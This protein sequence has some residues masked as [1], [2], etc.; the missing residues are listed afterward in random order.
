MYQLNAIPHSR[1]YA[2]PLHIRSR[3]SCH[4]VIGAH[5]S[6][7]FILVRWYAGLLPRTDPRFGTPKSW[8]ILCNRMLVGDLSPSRLR[9]RHTQGI[10]GG[11]TP[12]WFLNCSY[13]SVLHLP[14]HNY[15]IRL[16]EDRW[17]SVWAHQGRRQNDIE[18]WRGWRWL[19]Y[20]D[21]GCVKD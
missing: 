6:R 21:D 15:D 16:V 20:E 18:S 9:S 11:W 14:D 7:R 10:W 1:H 13:D 19:Q 5:S 8:F 17:W 2:L 3:R 4:G 12:R